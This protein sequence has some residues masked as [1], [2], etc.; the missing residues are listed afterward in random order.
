[1]V[2][3]VLK[4]GGDP[5]LQSKEMLSPFYEIVSRPNNMY[6]NERYQIIELLLDY[7]GDKT[8]TCRNGRTAEDVAK[9][10]GDRKTIELL[11]KTYSGS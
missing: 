6:A 4:A 7:G 11:E 9:E 8:L 10:I 3:A 2:E 1:M 5:N